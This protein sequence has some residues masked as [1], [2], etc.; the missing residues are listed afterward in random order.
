M[1]N[2][3]RLVLSDSW[4]SSLHLVW[5]FPCNV[6]S[7]KINIESDKSSS[8]A[9]KNIFLNLIA[10][11]P[12]FL[13]WWVAKLIKMIYYNNGI[14]NNMKNFNYLIE[15]DQAK[16]WCVFSKINYTLKLCFLKS[17]ES[18]IISELWSPFRV[19]IPIS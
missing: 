16:H 3:F 9:Q 19:P 10:I 14:L 4:C 2:F 13:S 11:S 15:N 5:Q 17:T 18:Q 6:S 8:K 1:C 7:P 12:C